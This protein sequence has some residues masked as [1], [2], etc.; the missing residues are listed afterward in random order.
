MSEDEYRRLLPDL[1]RIDLVSGQVLL[2]PHISSQKVY[3]FSQGVCSITHVTADGRK[4]GV[5]LIGNEGLLG[6][7][8][9]G[10][11]ADSGATACMEI[12]GVAHLLDAEILRR[13]IEHRTALQRAIH[14]YSEAFIDGLMQSIVC[15]A[16]HSIEM[17][18]AR[19]LLDIRDRLGRNDLPVT[20]Q[21]LADL[22]G[23]RRASITVAAAA[24]QRA[25]LIDHSH[26][27][28]VITDSVGLERAACEC[29]VAIKLR[30]ARLVV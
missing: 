2:Q 1:E 16:L 28:T 23:V 22:L 18:C 11:H 9:F 4:A 30:F 14:R 21:T 12:G 19:C 13:E 20:Q 7:D 3:F 8:L 26:K 6:L 29:Y 24:L 15:N 25:G 10:P 17:R 5:A 27:H